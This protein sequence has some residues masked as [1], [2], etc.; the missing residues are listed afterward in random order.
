MCRNTESAHS[1]HEPVCVIALIAGDR[2]ATCP[3]RQPAEHLERG[4]TLGEAGRLGEFQVY[5]QRAAVL[6]EQVPGVAELGWGGVGLAGQGRLGIG[7]GLM[8]LV[9]AWL[10]V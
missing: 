6:H 5:D 8:R 7:R 10:A 4:V 2:A 1:R 9:A 3:G